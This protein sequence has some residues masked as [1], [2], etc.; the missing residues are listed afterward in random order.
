MDRLFEHVR[1][2]LT[3]YFPSLDKAKYCEWWTHNR[4]HSASHQLHFDS[5][6]EGINGLRHPLL[7]VVL[8]LTDDV[9]GPTLVTNQKRDEVHLTY[10]TAGGWLCHPKRNRLIAFPN[11]LHGVLPG[12]GQMPAY[13]RRHTM[14]LSFWDAVNARKWDGPGSTRAVSECP[15]TWTKR[16]L[17]L[18]GPLIAMLDRKQVWKPRPVSPLIVPHIWENLD[19]TPLTKEDIHPHIQSHQCFQF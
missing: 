8:Y 17:E 12:K 13:K 4:H 11:Y 6:N 7:T 3:P 14:V 16:A 15:F 1:T 2:S 10:H 9:G 18:A 5:D 19:G